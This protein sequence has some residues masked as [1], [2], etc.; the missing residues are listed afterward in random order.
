MSFWTAL[1]QLRTILATE[2][3]YDSP[4]SEELLEQIRENIEALFMLLLD[5][6]DSGSATSD[7]PN[8]TTGVL[9]DTGAAYDAD[10]HNGRTL[11][12][13]SGL[14]IGNLYTIDDTTATT[15]V[16]TGDNLYAD[17]VRSADTYKVM[18]DL[19]NNTDGIDHDGVNS[20]M[21]TNAINQAAMADRAIGQAELKSTTGSVSTQLAV[22]TEL[23]LP[24]GEYGF[25]PQFKTNNASAVAYW[26]WD[27]TAG[28]GK[29]GAYVLG[30]TY[31]TTVRL[32][33]SDAA[34]IAY[35]QQ[36][37]IQASGEVH[38]IYILRDKLTKIP[39]G[40]MY[41]S[42]DHPCM[43]NG[44]KPKLC[45]HP[46]PG[47]DS[48]TNEIVV[49]NPTPEEVLE[50]Q[51]ATVEKTDDKPNRDLLQVI[52]EDYEIDEATEPAWPD[53]PVTV[54]LPE[55]WNEA[56]LERRRVR[57]IKMK[58]PQPEGMLVKSLKKKLG[59]RK[60]DL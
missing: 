54:G 21:I 44:N 48:K 49:I 7:P 60:E 2:T 8:N 39:T 30:T 4:N 3:D 9:A 15:L 25:H 33:V 51:R 26:G 13:K 34:Y 12:I 1:S 11:L 37:Y 52:A 14:A 53:V 32:S 55:D 40:D 47:Y 17:G 16:C 19:K 38:W 41:Q 5:T 24:G 29:W 45:P 27:A 31:L 50:M 36:R 58:I 57:P 18:Y 22:G 10:E 28:L 23:T 59:K 20:K 43:G 35:A 6:G 56:W 42:P 46:F